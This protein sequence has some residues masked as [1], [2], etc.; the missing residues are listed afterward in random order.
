MGHAAADPFL[1]LLRKK[2]GKVLVV[3]DDPIMQNMMGII[4][5]RGGIEYLS[6]RDGE[7]AVRMWENE[8]FFLI[9]MDLQ[10]PR[11]NGL[12]A[13]EAIRRREK[14]TKNHV[15]I[16]AVT[17]YATPGDDERCRAAGM[18][19]YVTKPVDFNRLYSIIDKFARKRTMS[20]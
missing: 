1:R 2:A 17:A 16:V 13:T 7:E 4:L 18:D 20:G 8:D 5:S 10:M 3:E 19:D 6:A 14:E 9:L 15:P 12:E 11:M